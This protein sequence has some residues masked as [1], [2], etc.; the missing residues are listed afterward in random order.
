[1][2][3]LCG[4]ERH[5]YPKESVIERMASGVALHDDVQDKWRACGAAVGQRGR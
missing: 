2:Q 1:L 4:T 5:V 3:S